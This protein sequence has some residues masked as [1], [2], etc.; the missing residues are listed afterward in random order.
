MALADHVDG[1]A[2]IYVGGFGAG[3]S[4]GLSL[5]GV[6]EEGVD[7]VV[8]KYLEPKKSGAAGPSVP[9]DL[10]RMGMDATISGGVNVYDL[11]ALQAIRAEGVADGVMPALG[12]MMASS[13]ST[14]RLVIASADEPWRFYTACLR[15]PQDHRMAVKYR[16]MR[17]SWYSWIFT[18]ATALTSATIPLYDHTAA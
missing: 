8:N 1:P 7:I 9:A 18:P 14:Y 17:L 4:G 13:G 16:T 11:S 6:A 12:S 15:G 2:A 3:L 10:Q 5:L